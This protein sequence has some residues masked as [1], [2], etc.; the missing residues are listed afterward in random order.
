MPLRCRYVFTGNPTARKVVGEYPGGF[1]GSLSMEALRELGREQSTLA[2][3]LLK[4]VGI[5]ATTRDSEGANS[6]QALALTT[7]IGKVKTEVLYR[8]K[9]KSVEAL[10]DAVREEHAKV[11]NRDGARRSYCLR[12]S[13]FPPLSTA[14]PGS[15]P[16]ALSERRAGRRAGR[17]ACR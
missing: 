14:Y 11:T 1:V 5:G 9:M 10:E 8:N 13:S 4:L 6:E 15:L 3:K 17:R 7:T 2:L 16:L 12:P